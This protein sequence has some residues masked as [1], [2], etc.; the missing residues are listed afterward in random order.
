M[1]ARFAGP[2]HDG[3][4]ERG[5]VDGT[6]TQGGAKA[7]ALGYKSVALTGPKAGLAHGSH[8]AFV[9]SE[10]GMRHDQGSGRLLFKNGL[11]YWITNISPWLNL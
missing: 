1:G 3:A 7:L 8:A 4:G 2:Q 11:P 5:N 9:S 6:S 10:K